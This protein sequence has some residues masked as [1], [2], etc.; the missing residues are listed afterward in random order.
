MKHVADEKNVQL[1][2]E[3]GIGKDVEYFGS[4]KK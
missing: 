2:E 4:H 3:T 1:L